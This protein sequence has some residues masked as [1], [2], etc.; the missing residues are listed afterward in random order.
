MCLFLTDNLC[1]LNPVHI[2]EISYIE[3]CRVHVLVPLLM[4]TSLLALDTIDAFSILF[5]RHRTF[6][7]QAHV[8]AIHRFSIHT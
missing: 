5:R 8:V 2:L 4:P 6:A 1:P 3:N 7:F